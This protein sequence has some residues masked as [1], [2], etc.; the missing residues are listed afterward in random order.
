MKIRKL[1]FVLFVLAVLSMG[2]L[3][4]DV[5]AGSVERSFNPT[6]LVPGG[7]MQVDL[8]V[9]LTPG[10]T[11]YVLEETFPASW[12]LG[13]HK[14]L[15]LSNGKLSAIVPTGAVAKTYSYRLTVP[16]SANK[17]TFSGTYQFTGG[18][19]TAI[20]GDSMIDTTPT[21]PPPATCTPVAATE[22]TS[23]K[24]C[25][26]ADVLVDDPHTPATGCP[27]GK[28]CD[29]HNNCVVDLAA[30]TND[31]SADGVIQN[32]DG[33]DKIVVC[34]Q[35]GSCF[36]WKVEACASGVCTGGACTAVGGE[37]G[38]LNTLKARIS[39]V[40]TPTCLKEIDGYSYVNGQLP[41]ISK[42]AKALK[43][44]FQ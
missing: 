43:E 21:T 30:C 23:A 13:S 27:K 44:Y 35:E 24:I 39:C 29:A 18:A 5:S 14:D 10:E 1:Y 31:C 4:Q 9:K 2:L 11:F 17:G 26:A 25:N 32:C 40:L 6:T 34:R 7:Q 22:C 16:A 15:T 8:E 33:N 41:Q 12:T 3:A 19:Q 37:V 20:G 36:K 42:I 28:K 38:A